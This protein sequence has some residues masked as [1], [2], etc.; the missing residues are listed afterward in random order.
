MRPEEHPFGV[1]LGCL[2]GV[3]LLVLILANTGR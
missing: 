2:I 1:A 3:V